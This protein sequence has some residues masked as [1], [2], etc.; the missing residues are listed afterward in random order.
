MFAPWRGS[1]QQTTPK[2]TPITKQT[3]N[4]PKTHKTRICHGLWCQKEGKFNYDGNN[5]GK[6]MQR[7]AKSRA[8]S[9]AEMSGGPD[10]SGQ[11][12]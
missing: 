6:K 10:F 4:K 9:G 3:K 11:S 2:K 7:G 1:G 8:I 12:P 5:H